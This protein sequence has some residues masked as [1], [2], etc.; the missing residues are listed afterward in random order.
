MKILCEYFRKLREKDHME[1]LLTK[2]RIVLRTIED[3]VV[4]RPYSDQAMD[5]KTKKSW[6]DSRQGQEVFLFSETPTPAPRPT[7]IPIQ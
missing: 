2:G 7:V 6:F 3:I 4:D 1:V 5:C